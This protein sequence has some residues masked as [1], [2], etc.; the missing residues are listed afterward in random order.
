[1]GYL[2]GE[3]NQRRFKNEVIEKAEK[4]IIYLN[5]QIRKTNLIEVRNT[6]NV[7][8]EEQ[9]KLSMTANATEEY[10]FKTLSPS[11]AAEKKI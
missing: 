7:I 1:M 2:F 6:L 9:F 3:R 10:L 11:Y 4:S 5:E 8:I